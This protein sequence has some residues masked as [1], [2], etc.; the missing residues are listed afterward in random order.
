MIVNSTEVQNNFGRYLKM[1]ERED[2]IITK[3]GKKVARMMEY[4]ENDDYILREGSSAYNHQGMEVSYEKFLEITRESENRYEFIDGQIYLL[5]SPKYTHQKIVIELSGIM[6]SWFED[7]ECQPLTAPFDVTL[8]NRDKANVVQPDLLV[9][10]DREKIGE[11]D[12][13]T[14]IPTLVVEVLSRSTRN[15]DMIRKLD[16]YRAAGVKEYWLLNPFAS[17]FSVYMFKDREIEKVVTFRK[18]ETARS[19]VFSGLEV[20]LDKVFG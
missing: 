16:L 9:I 14:G 18:S 7:K 10:C 11:D 19:F 8:Y 2:I 6:N 12:T 5:S 15:R 13:Y 17:E 20:E 1:V 4:R 3:N